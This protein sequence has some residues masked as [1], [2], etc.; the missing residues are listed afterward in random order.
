MMPGWEIRKQLLDIYLE[1]FQ[2]TP[3]LM[4]IGG[5]ESLIYA[6]ERGAGWRAD[7]LGGSSQPR[8]GNRI[9]ESGISD[10]WKTAPVVFEV[11]RTFERHKESGSP[12][13][14]FTI[15]EALRWHASSV[16]AKSSPI[17]QEWAGKF[18]DFI[19]RLGYR[20]E[21]RRLSYPGEVR[22][23]SMM[24]LQMWWVN[25]GVAPVYR[26][27]V[28]A[29]ELRNANGSGVIRLDNDL[30]K[31]LP[32]DDIVVNTP[33]W[34][35]ELQPGTYHVRVGLLDPFTG[36]PAIKLAIQGRTEDNWHDLGAVEVLPWDLLP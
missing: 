14:D 36:K 21:L 29:V 24:P 18:M 2:K 5:G 8:Y 25:S 6:T 35:P 33:V 30:T 16:N 17:P 19:D 13:I 27:Y 1:A 11:G 26:M 31:W 32:G 23:G 9:A 22:A 4:L 12:D 7:S 3:L 10:V 15:S 34:V 20:F 28:L